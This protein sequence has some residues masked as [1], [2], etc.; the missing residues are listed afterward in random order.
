VG[1]SGLYLQWYIHG[2][3]DSLPPRGNLMHTNK[4]RKHTRTYTPA[5]IEAHARAHEANDS[6][7]HL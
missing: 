3:P 4:G 6:T 5:R 2:P 1:G 7:H